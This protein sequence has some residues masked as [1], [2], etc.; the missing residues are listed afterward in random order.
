MDRKGRT[1][2][3]GVSAEEMILLWKPLKFEVMGA[4]LFCCVCV[5]YMYVFKRYIHRVKFFS[6]TS[7]GYK[8]M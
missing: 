2:T 3:K 6:N 1:L 5:C 4:I 7:K 8:V